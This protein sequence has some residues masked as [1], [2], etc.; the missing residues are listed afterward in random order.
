[1]ATISNALRSALDMAFRDVN[2][3][4]KCEPFDFPMAV[5]VMALADDDQ[6]DY[7]RV[8]TELASCHGYQGIADLVRLVLIHSQ[9]K[10]VWLD[11]FVK[12]LLKPLNAVVP[13]EISTSG[14]KLGVPLGILQTAADTGSYRVELNLPEF[15]PLVAAMITD[16]QGQLARQDCGKEYQ[17]KIRNAI[18]GFCS[19]SRISGSIGPI[20]LVENIMSESLV[21]VHQKKSQHTML[22]TNGV[23]RTILDAMAYARFRYQKSVLDRAGT[24]V[25]PKTYVFQGDVGD[26]NKEWSVV[27]YSQDLAESDLFQKYPGLKGRVWHIRTEVLRIGRIN[28]A[29][30]L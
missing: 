14:F 13:N 20:G 12:T 4:V 25:N 17:G 2:D 10:S 24:Q 28:T 26:G 3:H 7:D 8:I 21:L 18:D 30:V 19:A 29:R 9:H 22:Y 27:H 1:M 5:L 11:R 23:G 6:P 15:V 16:D